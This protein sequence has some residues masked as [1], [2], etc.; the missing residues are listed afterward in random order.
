M[1]VTTQSA[2]QTQKLG[3]SMAKKYQNGGILALIGLLGAGKTTF[4]Q[5]FAQGLGIKQRLTSP[6]F[7]LMREYPI[8]RNKSGK[9]YHIDL[10][11]LENTSQMEQLGLAEIFANPKNI[12][13]IEWA[14]KLGSL[15]PQKAVKI[16]FKPLSENS[17]EI[18]IE[19]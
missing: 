5:G 10:Y 2:A 8:P 9:L 6:T 4:T 7:I 18:K 14:E 12:V 13:L 3:K 16:V 19:D 11:R 17:R 1:M 15:L